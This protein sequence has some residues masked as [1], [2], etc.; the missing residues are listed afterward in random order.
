[1]FCTLLVI[2]LGT[3]DNRVV[4]LVLEKRWLRKVPDLQIFSNPEQLHNA[5]FELLLVRVPVCSTRYFRG[6]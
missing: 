4:Y 5:L 3:S 6:M 1:M 2:D